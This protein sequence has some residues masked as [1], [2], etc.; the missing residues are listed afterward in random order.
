M[1]SNIKV[2]FWLRCINCINENLDL[3]NYD[4]GPTS[5]MVGVESESNFLIVHCSKHNVDIKLFRLADEE[6]DLFPKVC[7]SCEEDC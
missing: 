4:L 6:K 1:Q 7:D 5:L 2:D 3:F